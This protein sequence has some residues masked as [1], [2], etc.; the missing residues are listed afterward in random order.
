MRLQEQVAIY[1]KASDDN[2]KIISLWKNS[3]M[4]GLK[5]LHD[6]VVRFDH[7]RILIQTKVGCKFVDETLVSHRTRCF[8]AIGLFAKPAIRSKALF[9][10]VMRS[11]D[12]LSNEHSFLV[13][14]SDGHTEETAN[15]TAARKVECRCDGGVL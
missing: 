15:P 5:H 4:I 7:D 2:V 10:H 1:I 11:Q 12:R 13:I 14:M 8:I 9:T 3:Q 6:C